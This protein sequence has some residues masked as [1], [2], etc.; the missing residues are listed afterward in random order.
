MKFLVNVSE[1]GIIPW[2]YGVA[3][4]DWARYEHVCAPV[5]FNVILALARRVYFWLVFA[6]VGSAYDKAVQTGI[7]LERRV[8]QA[9]LERQHRREVVALLDAVAAQGTK[10]GV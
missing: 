5:P 3:W 2:G 6:A 8:Q 9:E 7:A 10:R 1:G 4:R